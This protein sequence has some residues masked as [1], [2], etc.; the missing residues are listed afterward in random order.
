LKLQANELSEV[1]LDANQGAA[2]ASNP[3][4]DVLNGQVGNAQGFPFL[5]DAFAILEDNVSHHLSTTEHNE[6]VT[7]TC[8]AHLQSE[9]SPDEY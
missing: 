1:D 7:S 2:Q 3:T 8:S 9:L 4:N 5:P 6:Y